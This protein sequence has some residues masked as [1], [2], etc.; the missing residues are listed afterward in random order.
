MNVQPCFP[1][2]DNLRVTS[3]GNKTVYWQG[4]ANESTVFWGNFLPRDITEGS[5][6]CT[7]RSYG[8]PKLTGHFFGTLHNIAPPNLG[9][10]STLYCIVNTSNPQSCSMDPLR[11]PVTNH[12]PT[13][14]DPVLLRECKS[15]GCNS[16][17]N[18]V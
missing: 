9:V 4:E 8:M 1:R 15:W 18:R 16:V 12:K 10:L 2:F 3:C 11:C 17:C 13:P 7:S 6:V 14:C 5:R